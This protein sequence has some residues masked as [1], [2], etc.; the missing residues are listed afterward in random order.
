MDFIK[1][2]ILAVIMTLCTLNVNG[3][4][5]NNNFK[6]GMEKINIMG[7][8][9]SDEL[10]SFLKT[11]SDLDIEKV[12]KVNDSYVVT[13]HNSKE[14]KIIPENY[15][16]DYFFDKNN[17]DAVRILKIISTTGPK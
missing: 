6:M 1:K 3:A 8:N 12:E 16:N 2:I 15:V 11:N 9:H 10:E 14:N 13:I 5:D 17:K 4:S 7:K